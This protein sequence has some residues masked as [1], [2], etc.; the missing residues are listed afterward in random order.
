MG[1]FVFRRLED[2]FQFFRTDRR[3]DDRLYINL[4]YWAEKLEATDR[5]GGHHEWS[6]DKFR[7]VIEGYLEDASDELKETVRDDV[8]TRI[9]DGQHEAFQAANS[10]EHEGFTFSD[11]WDHEFRE[12]TWRFVWCCYALAWGIRQYDQAKMPIS[13]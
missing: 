12:Y 4:G 10:F 1:T 13:V 8:L 5:A 11:L 9:G 3:G 7:S 2:M 6:E